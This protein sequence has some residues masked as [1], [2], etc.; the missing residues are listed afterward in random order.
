MSVERK[1]RL[2]EWGQL[3]D[4]TK[5]PT[6]EYILKTDGSL[7]KR[8][9]RV[10]TDAEGSILTGIS[11]NGVADSYVLMLGDSFL[12]SLFID[13]ESRF[14]AIA[15]RLLKQSGINVEIWNGGYSGATSLHLFVNLITKYLKFHNKIKMLIFFQPSC[16]VGPLHH[17][18]GYWNN[19]PF[20][21]PILE[22]RNSDK[23]LFNSKF[24]L[25]HLACL[26]NSLHAVCKN[27]SIPLHIVKTPFK[28]MSWE[29]DSYAKKVFNN[30]EHLE[31]RK[32][33]LRSMQLKAELVARKNDAKVLDLMEIMDR[34]PELFY[35]ELHLNEKGSSYI[36]GVIGEYIKNS[37]N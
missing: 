11:P 22:G 1:V 19:H 17:K 21:A 14:P 16:D 27:Y 31:E 13:E 20:Y 36:G 6:D 4:T 3:V 10:R 8:A 24:D 32:F 34:M 12:E 33:T 15:E 18:T 28:N 2:K 37:L 9:Y 7:E 25:E 30:E 26:H 5:T 35:D 29:D 23:G